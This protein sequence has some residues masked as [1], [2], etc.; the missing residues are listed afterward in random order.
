MIKYQYFDWFS[1]NRDGLFDVL[2]SAKDSIVGQKLTI[3]QVHS[4]LARVVREFLPIRIKKVKDNKVDSGWVWVGG[5]YCSGS[6]QDGKKCITID[7][8]YNKNDK[9]ISISERRFSRLCIGFADTVLHEIIHMRQYRR[10]NWRVIPD[11]PS[12]AKRSSQREEQSYLG[13]RDEIDA[14]AFN[15]ACELMD[16]FNFSEKKV[17]KYMNENQKGL[18]RRHNCYRM[19]LKAFS[20]DHSHPI[21]KRLKKKVVSYLPQAKLGKPY[22]NS[23]WINY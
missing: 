11:Y 7:F 2:Y 16:K 9:Q 12:T 6:D 8:A 10:R 20:H 19:Y 14:Y 23:E 3:E 18:N 17:I 15:I 21:M 13:C 22:R 4:R 1:L 5:S